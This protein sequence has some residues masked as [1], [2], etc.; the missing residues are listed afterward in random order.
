MPPLDD[1]E[2]EELE[3]STSP[4]QDAEPAEKEQPTDTASSS[5]ATGDDL[6]LLSVVRDVVTESRQEETASPAEGEEVDPEVGEQQT[7]AED[8][9]DV[10]FHKHPRFQQ[11]LRKSKAY[12][13][14]AK[15][16][17]NVRG[18]LDTHGLTSEEAADGMIIMG[19]MKTDPVK[20][21][22]MLRPRVQNLL[23][24]AGEVLSDE[25]KAR[26]QRGEMS[27]E[28]AL[29]VSRA[30]A[31]VKAVATR[32]SFEQQRQE[33]QQQSAAGEEL[34]TAASEWEAGRMRKDPNFEAKVVPL[35]KEIL[36]LQQKE[37]RPKTRQGVLDQL[38]RAY[39]AVNDAIRP[40]AAPP[41]ARTPAAPAV[42]KPAI[43][44]VTGGQVAGGSKPE[45][46]STIDIV[47]ANRRSA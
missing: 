46:K 11:L 1:N 10:P 35:Q 8:Y 4:A 26:V 38:N 6:D 25:L 33:R 5:D 32:Q 20:A 22:E 47:R 31:A 29:E 7:E 17:Q 45:Y 12:E 19:L 27:Q 14:D 43:K 2:I 36:F 16:F 42:K 37:G 13:E 41:S 23:V 18:F 9:S 21:W 44:P 40:A 3:P 30:Q 28:A 39:K 34:R 15:A 24:A